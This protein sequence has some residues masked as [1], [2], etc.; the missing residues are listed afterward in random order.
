MFT[1]PLG[2]G[3]DSSCTVP[4]GEGKDSLCTA[5]PPPPPQE[6]EKTPCTKSDIPMGG[7]LAFSC[8]VGT[9]RGPPV[10]TQSTQGRL[11]TTFQR[12][13]KPVQGAVM[14]APTKCLV[15]LYSRPAAQRHYRSHAHSKQLRILQSAVPGPKTRQSLE[16]RYRLKFTKQV[17]GH[18]KVQDGNH[19][20]DTGL[21]QKRRMGYLYRSHRRIPPCTDPYPLSKYLRFHHKGVTYQ[22]VSLPFGL[23]IAPLVFTSLVKE[24][25]LLA[26]QQGIILH[27]YLDDWSIRA[28]SKEECH[29]QTQALLSLVKDLGFVVN[30]RSQNSVPPR[31]STS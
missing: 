9:S 13:A 1:V 23:A 24:V 5:P 7:R 10:Y 21:P 30:S 16:A 12:M 2:E 15:D 26:L 20:I 22:F 3:K 11:Q 14:Q 31:G 4:L 18:T 19:G 27:Q 17:P 28:P 29:S 8:P 25:K 6:R